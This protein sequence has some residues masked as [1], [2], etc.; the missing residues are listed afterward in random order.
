MHNRIPFSIA[1]YFLYYIAYFIVLVYSRLL[2]Y[3][4]GGE[5]GARFGYTKCIPKREGGG[6]RWL[7]TVPMK[8]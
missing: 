1:Q 8:N 2:I 5:I 4:V 6:S 3:N 7:K